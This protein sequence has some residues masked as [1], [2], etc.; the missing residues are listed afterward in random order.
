MQSHPL[1]DTRFRPFATLFGTIGVS[2]IW[3]SWV[4]AL[5][6]KHTVEVGRVRDLGICWLVRRV[7]LAFDTDVM[8][9][10]PVFLSRPHAL[11]DWLGFLNF[12]FLALSTNLGMAFI[13]GAAVTPIVLL[14]W[15]K[16]PGHLSSS[17][18]SWFWGRAFPVGILVA[19]LAP[20]SIRP[21]TQTFIAGYRLGEILALAAQPLIWL[22]LAWVIATPN[23]VDRMLRWSGLGSVALC[24]TAISAAACLSVT[25]PENDRRVKAGPQH[26]NVLLV[27]IDSLRA[28]H[29]HCYGYH[30]A[31]SPTIDSLAAEG[32]RFTT[33]V[34]PTSWTLPSHVTLL[35][36]LEPDLHGVNLARERLSPDAVL[37]PDELRGHGYTTAGFVS[38]PFMDATY[39]FFR[40]FDLYDDYTA[41]RRH[42]RAAATDVTSPLLLDSVDAWLSEWDRS[43]RK[44]PFFIFLHMWDVH[45]DYLPPPPFD[46]MFD[47]AYRGSIN[48]ERIFTSP[49]IHK[50]MDPG[51]LAH[52]V[53]LYDGEIRFTDGYLGKILRLLRELDIFDSTVVAITAD[54]GE[55]FFEHGD[56]TH[57]KTLYDEAVLVPWV[58]RFPAKIPAGRVVERQ[59]R[60]SDVAPTI[61][62]LA[63]I[64]RT[65][66]FGKGLRSPMD[67]R[68]DLLSLISGR[69]EPAQDSFAIGNLHNNIHS[70]RTN[71]FK[72]IRHAD[73]RNELFDLVADPRERSDMSQLQPQLRVALQKQLTAWKSGA[74]KGEN[75]E[76]RFGIDQELQD[77]LRSLGYLR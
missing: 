65:G 16:L 62:S 14:I 31:T 32:V 7:G 22:C 13:A 40:G 1:D 3:G 57:G 39:G 5:Y 60:L 77:A 27:S 2:A 61:L 38:G 17:R 41:V 18:V 10:L 37:L 42:G 26:P 9:D 47:A 50:D 52:V 68:L 53:A 28:D 12:W 36:S 58:I 4:G 75:P 34:A 19:F 21:F 44:K 33:V 20:Y 45:Y 72:L 24:V 66:E 56:K 54:H 59:V 8:L 71:R 51:D 63:G 11:T 23:Q 69:S 55:E 74:D 73:G 70:I 67:D 48:G 46:T 29:L 35:T 25:N 64:R 49:L 43:G 15:E 76:R 6:L 30:R